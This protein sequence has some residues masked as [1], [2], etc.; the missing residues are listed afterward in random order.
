MSHSDAGFDD[1]WVSVGYGGEVYEASILSSQFF[2][3]PKTAL[4]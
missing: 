1:E 4:K 2:C 3:E